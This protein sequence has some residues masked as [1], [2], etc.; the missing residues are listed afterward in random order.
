V[1]AGD[2][3]SDSMAYP[4]LW[5]TPDLLK[6]PAPALEFLRSTST[7]VPYH[8][9]HLIPLQPLRRTDSRTLRPP[10]YLANR[11]APRRHHP[12]ALAQPF[13]KARH[14]YRG[15]APSRI[16]SVSTSTSD[17]TMCCVPV[18]YFRKCGVFRCASYAA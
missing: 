17:F 9:P 11:D 1:S 12:C 15:L 3:T 13:A 2:I 14:G 7:R 5:S 18:L 8:R 16:G 10:Q 4:Y 6:A